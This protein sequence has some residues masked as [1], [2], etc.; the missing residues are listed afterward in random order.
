M[1][2]IVSFEMAQQLGAELLSCSP[3]VIFRCGRPGVKALQQATRTAV[4]HASADQTQGR[5]HQRSDPGRMDVRELRLQGGSVWQG[6]RMGLSLGSGEEA[7]KQAE[8]EEEDHLLC[9]A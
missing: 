6:A 9:A 1:N 2:F 4:R 7:A 3:E 5:V 8:G